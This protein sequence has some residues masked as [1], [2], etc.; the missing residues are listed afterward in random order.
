MENSPNL[1]NVRRPLQ[2]L[3]RTTTAVAL[4]HLLKLTTALLH[5]LQL[6]TALLRPITALLQHH[7]HQFVDPLMCPVHA[8]ILLVENVLQCQPPIYPVVSQIGCA[9]HRRPSTHNIKL[10]Q[11]PSFFRFLVADAQIRE[12]N[13]EKV[14]LQV[15]QMWPTKI[16]QWYALGVPELVISKKNR[17]LLVASSLR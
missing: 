1:W 9:L 16:A 12:V 15:P 11:E 6:T 3:R 2:D 8:R 14:P 4:R 5:L 13:V 7:P 10:P 17:L